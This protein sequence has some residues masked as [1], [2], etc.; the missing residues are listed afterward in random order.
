MSSHFMAHPDFVEGVSARLIERKKTRPNWNPNT[1]EEVKPADVEPFFGISTPEAGGTLALLESGN[2]ATY[3]SYPHAIFGLPTEEE[4]LGVWSS[5]RLMKEEVVQHF[6]K[7]RDGK[8]GIREKVDEVI[9]R[10]QYERALY[11]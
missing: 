4:I 9:D 3:S 11:S 6:L 2:H 5:G 10:R 7:Q 1:L 8:V